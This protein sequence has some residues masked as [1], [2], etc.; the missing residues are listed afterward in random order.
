MMYLTLP[1]AA[2]KDAFYKMAFDYKEYGE[3]RYFKDIIE[4]GFDYD[5]YLARLRRNILGVNLEERMVPYTTYWLI[6]ENRDAIYGVSRLRHKLN[7]ISFKEGGHIGYD[8]PPSR[9]NAGNATEL[10]RLTIIKAKDMGIARALLTCDADNAASARVIIKNGG[11][12]ENQVVSDF[13]G[14][15]VNR[16]WIEC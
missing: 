12:F 6:D 10:L 9:R 14:R 4:E 2:L 5:A 11:L 8:V 13:T 16:Y 1:L 15:I 3:R 7:Q